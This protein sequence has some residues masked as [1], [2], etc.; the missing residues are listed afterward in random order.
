[1][2]LN[3]FAAEPARAG[4]RLTLARLSFDVCCAAWGPVGAPGPRELG[5]RGAAPAGAEAAA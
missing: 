4:R 2:V 5:I 3:R 1:M